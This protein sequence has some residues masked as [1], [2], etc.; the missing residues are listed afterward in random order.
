MGRRRTVTLDIRNLSV[1]F[2]TRAGT[3]PAVRGV[4]LSIE[5][6]GRV[7]LVGESGCGKT[8]LALALLGLLPRNARVNGTASLGS[9]N[10]LDPAVAASLRGR[11]IAI[12]WSNAERYFNPVLP[13]GTQIDEASAWHG[14]RASAAR[15]R[16]LALLRA[17]GLDDPERICRAYP[18]QLSG[19]MNQRAM[20]AM[21]LM[22]EPRLLLV[23]EP[24]RGLDDE[25]RERVIGALLGVER[26]SMLI[27]THDVELVERIA[28]HVHFMRAGEI[29]DHGPVPDALRSPGH[30]YSEELVKAGLDA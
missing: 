14:G 6:G 20:I 19:G 24:T 21:S 10:L 22:N 17:V 8:V 16:T 26:S 3:V 9:S 23:D 12:C 30:P 5:S 13:I 7:A 11:E 27:I 25:N 29:L 1:T 18:F 15:Q 4:S 28:Q 2:Q